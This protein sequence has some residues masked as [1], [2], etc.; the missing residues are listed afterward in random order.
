VEAADI[1]LANELAHE[2]LGRS[3]DELPPQT[4]R[5]LGMIEAWVQVQVQQHALARNAVRLT[6]RQLRSV[7]GMSDAAIRV[8]LERLITMEYVRAAAG[9]NGQRYEYELLFDGDLERSAPQMI[10]LIDA[11]GL[12][13]ASVLPAVSI[14]TAGTLQGVTGDLAPGSQGACTGLAPTS[15]SIDPAENGSAAGTL[16]AS[17]AENST[18][19][20]LGDAAPSGRNPSRSRRAGARSSLPLA[21]SYAA[22]GR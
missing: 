10:G 16:P 11:D 1:A 5:V 22:A 8:H 18:D 4:R 3:L 12:R 17:G 20:R 15:Q 6:R 2:V 9:R 14:D 13:A 7:C 19:G 21:A